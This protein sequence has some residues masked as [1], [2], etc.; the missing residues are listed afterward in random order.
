[1]KNSN[2]KLL[3]ICLTLSLA[4]LACSENIYT[5]FRS[6]GDVPELAEVIEPT[7]TLPSDPT[8]VETPLPTITY[9]PEPTI[10]ATLLPTITFTPE[11]TLGIGS[12]LVNPVDGAEMVYVPEG[13]FLMGSD[14]EDAMDN[15][16][17]MHTVFLDG[18]WIYQ[19]E[20]TNDQFTAFISATNHQTTAE[21]KGWSFMFVDNTMVEV[22]G[23]YWMAPEGPGSSITDR[24]FWED[25]PVVQVSW[26]DALAYC[27]WAGG[28][29]PTEA[30][31]EKAAR[32]TDARKYPW[33]NEPEIGGASACVRAN[34]EECKTIT[35]P[36]GHFS[37][38][39]SPYGALDM[40][41]NVWEWVMDWAETDYYKNSPYE[42]PQGPESGSYRILRG[43]SWKSNEWRLRVT[44]RH[45]LPPDTTFPDVGI[46]CVHDVTP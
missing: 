19:T 14:D 21:E 13:E 8:L 27:Q 26:F 41:G 7:E 24:Y 15:E 28:R 25:H 18:F 9:T 6:Q 30:E 1:M 42:N 45:G 23:A 12:V 2:Q 44:L 40:A 10:T 17:P 22:N 20:V 11:P 43:G 16:K 5:R 29:L 38:G 36:V 33:G 37:P 39:A 32:G 46:R 31:W 34:Y 4:M 35:L 3:I